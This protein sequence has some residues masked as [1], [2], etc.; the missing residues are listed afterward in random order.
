M[1][2]GFICLTDRSVTELPKEWQPLPLGA[3]ADV[4]QRLEHVIGSRFRGRTVTVET[5]DGALE[6]SVGDDDP[7][8]CV[9]VRGIL[10]SDA[11][12]LLRRICESIG[13]RYYDSEEGEFVEL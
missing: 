13:A 1:H 3:R 11:R 2:A 7:V 12:L 8:D 4:I 6:L 10:S 5:T 9:F